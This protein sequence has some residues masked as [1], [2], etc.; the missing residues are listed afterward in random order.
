M[1]YELDLYDKW[2]EGRAEG[3]KEGIEQGLEKGIEIGEAK[4]REEGIMQTAITALKQGIPAETVAS[5]TGL[6]VLEV[7]ALK[8]KV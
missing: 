8:N 7:E 4:G 2:R 5:F 6:S 1:K 3:I